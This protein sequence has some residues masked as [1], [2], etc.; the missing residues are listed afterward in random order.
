MSMK[1]LAR[2]GVPH[3]GEHRQAAERA[4]TDI[5]GHSAAA[6][7]GQPRRLSG[8]EVTYGAIY[9]WLALIGVLIG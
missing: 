2:R 6:E 7:L 1:R 4:A 5:E 3:R 8:H 9:Y